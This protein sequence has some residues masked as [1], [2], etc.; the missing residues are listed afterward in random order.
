MAVAQM[1]G[2]GM[3]IGTQLV[4][5]HIKTNDPHAFVESKKQQVAGLLTDF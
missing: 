5:L 2:M 4:H 3:S 1:I